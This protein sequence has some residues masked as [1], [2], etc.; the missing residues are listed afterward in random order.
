MTTPRYRVPISLAAWVA[1]TIALAG[2][3]RGPSGQAR[4]VAQGVA[5]TSS[6]IVFENEAREHVHVYLVS[7]QRQWFLGR[8]E[9][10]ALTILR[11]PNESLNRSPRRLQ[12][13]VLVGRPISPRVVL[14]PGAMFTI[15]QPASRFLMQD[16]RFVQGEL[17]STPIGR[18]RAAVRP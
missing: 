17:L 4:D 14:E 2:C 1:V 8:V 3:V 12:L 10:G 15:A 6:T 7:D 16:W 5:P 11:I 13:A 9:P 18:A